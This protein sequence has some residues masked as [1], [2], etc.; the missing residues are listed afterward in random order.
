ML[1]CAGE[2]WVSYVPDSSSA[3]PALVRFACR[4]HDHVISTCCFYIV[5]LHR[6]GTA[7]PDDNGRIL[8]TTAPLIST[9]RQPSL[10][11]AITWLGQLQ[12][13]L[14]LSIDRGSLIFGVKV[15]LVSDWSSVACDRRR[16][17]VDRRKKRAFGTG[18]TR[19]C[20]LSFKRAV[21]S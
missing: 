16:R 6:T 1:D 13:Y 15:L 17:N 5:Y 3:C 19:V 10:G 8:V 20:P 12:Q 11:P 2:G 7:L 9:C 21:L 18:V 14:P 4:A